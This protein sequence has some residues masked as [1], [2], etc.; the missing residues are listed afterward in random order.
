MKKSLLALGAACI[1]LSGMAASP[2]Q[3]LDTS[4][5]PLF[6]KSAEIQPMGKLQVAKANSSMKKAPAKIGAEDVITSVEGTKQNVTITGSGYYL[7]WG[8]ALS[9]YEEQ[10]A[11][12]HIVYGENNEV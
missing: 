1:A 3:K 10:E 5:K 12:S 4:S 11:A 8:I 6:N 2:L 7:F 9:T